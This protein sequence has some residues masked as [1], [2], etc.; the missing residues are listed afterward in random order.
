MLLDIASGHP[1]EAVGGG[2]G[3]GG[4]VGAARKQPCAV[5]AKET[6]TLGAYPG[7]PCGTYLFPPPHPW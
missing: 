1:G 6:V 5:W 7:A 2:G 4:A 3:G